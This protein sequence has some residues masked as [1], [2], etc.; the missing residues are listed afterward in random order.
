MWQKM[1][2]YLE[3]FSP[4]MVWKVISEQPENPVRLEEYLEGKCCVESREAQI[5]S[6]FWALAAIYQPLLITRQHPQGEEEEGRAT[7]TVATQTAAE[8]EEQPVLVAVVPIQKKK[9]KTK[10]GH[11]VRDEEEVGSSQEE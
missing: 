3:D 11:L 1:G 4:P 9:S 6:F 10:S 2:Q 5:T 7:G 8:P